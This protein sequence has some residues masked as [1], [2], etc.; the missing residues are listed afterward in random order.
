MPLTVGYSLPWACMYF[1]RVPAFKNGFSLRPAPA[2][3]PII[4]LHFW[5]SVRNLPDGNLIVTPS[6]PR[7]NTTADEPAAFIS[8]PPSPVFFSILHTTVPSGIDASARI[9]PDF[10]A[11]LVPTSIVLPTIVPLGAGTYEYLPSS[12]CILARGASRPLS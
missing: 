8:L 1:A 12:N 9:F 10:A 7:A 11:V 4:A 2:I 5:L 6:V 3:A